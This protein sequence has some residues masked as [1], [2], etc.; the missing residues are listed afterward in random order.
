MPDDPPC[1][2]ASMADL[3]RD[4]CHNYRELCLGSLASWSD[5]IRGLLRQKTT[6]LFFF[7]NFRHGTR[8][9]Q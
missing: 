3:I 2:V 1:I 9:G 6:F 4:F 7:F 5:G 8:N